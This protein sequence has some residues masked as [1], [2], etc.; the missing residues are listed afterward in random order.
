[1]NA[2]GAIVGLVMGIGSVQAEIRQAEDVFARWVTPESAYFQHCISDASLEAPEKVAKPFK[3][4]KSMLPLKDPLARLI[5]DEHGKV[6]AHRVGHLRRKAGASM[7]AFLDELARQGLASKALNDGDEGDKFNAVLNRYTGLFKALFSDPSANALEQ[8][9]AAANHFAEFSF[10]AKTFPELQKIMQTEETKPLGRFL[11][12]GMWQTL[13]GNGWKCWHKE[14]LKK[15]SK[16]YK[17]GK[18]VVY[19]AGG[20]DVYHLITHGVY[21]LKIIDPQVNV[22]ENYYADQW[23]WLLDNTV[24][25]IGDEMHFKAGKKKIVARRLEPLA[26]DFPVTRWQIFENDKAVGLLTFERRFATQADFKAKKNERLLMSFNEL[27]YVAL[28]HDQGGWPINPDKFPDA[29]E[30]HIKQLRKPINKQVV[31]N[32]CWVEEHN[33]SFLRLGTA[34]DA[35]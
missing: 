12:A 28:P 9:F 29:M 10:S 11:Y 30:M 14:T 23:Q 18:T 32:I 33:L 17:N 15:L 2:V 20:S 13:A 16:A 7:A 25:R 26:G 4:V 6:S 21:N 35:E 5:T 22:Q 31:Q 1:M 3:L 24:E 19:V 8:S 27:F 34:A